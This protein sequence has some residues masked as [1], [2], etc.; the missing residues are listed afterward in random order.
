[1]NLAVDFHRLIVVKIVVSLLCRVDQTWQGRN[2]LV[3]FL[4]LR[5]VN[6]DLLLK[7]SEV[8]VLVSNHRSQC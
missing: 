4:D 5:G 8:V 7:F 3:Q 6:A 1:M 2:S